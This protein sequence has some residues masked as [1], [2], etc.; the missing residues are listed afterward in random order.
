MRKLQWTPTIIIIL[1]IQTEEIPTSEQKNVLTISGKSRNKKFIAPSPTILLSIPPL[2]FMVWYNLNIPWGSFYYEPHLR[3]FSGTPSPCLF[4]PPPPLQLSKKSYCSIVNFTNDN[5]S[6]SF[7]FKEN[8]SGQTSN[9]GPKDVEIMGPLK[10]LHKV[11]MAL[12]CCWLIVKT[13]LH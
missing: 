11:C 10:Y 2:H 6:G 8:P 7:K 13:T 12:K 9:D 5:A 4:D 1:L 3:Y